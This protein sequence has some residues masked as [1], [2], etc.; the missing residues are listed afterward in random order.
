MWNAS[1]ARTKSAGWCSWGAALWRASYFCGHG[2]GRESVS[3]GLLDR[4]L[5]DVL[6]TW[7]ST[8]HLLPTYPC[9][10]TP[11]GTDMDI[12][13]NGSWLPESRRATAGHDAGVAHRTRHPVQCTHRQHL[14]LW[15][16]TVTKIRFDCDASGL[17]RSIGSV[18]ELAGTAAFP[19]EAPA[20]KELRSI[21]FA[22]I[23][24]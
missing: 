6:A 18:S 21:R 15:L 5:R 23:M 9:V 16:K 22:S 17:C 13:E 14:R 3:L 24:V 11:T 10:I 8:Y 2:A 20:W 19:K 7:P 12:L 1:A 4:W